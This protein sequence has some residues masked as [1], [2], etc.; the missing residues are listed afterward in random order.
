M[1]CRS[2]GP[3]PA[4]RWRSSENC[5]SPYFP[6]SNYFCMAC[7]NAPR[8]RHDMA[9]GGFE[10]S[11][12]AQRIRIARSNWKACRALRNI[13]LAAISN[14]SPRRAIGISIARRSS[15]ARRCNKACKT[16]LRRAGF[17]GARRP[18]RQRHQMAAPRPESAACGSPRRRAYPPPRSCGRVAEGGGLL[19]RYRVV[20]PY[21]GFESLRLRQFPASSLR[22]QGEVS[23]EAPKEP[24]LPQDISNPSEFARKRFLRMIEYG[25]LPALSPRS[26][27][28]AS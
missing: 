19:N 17:V 6:G 8:P 15:L 5:K 1:L 22:S 24:G 14:S 16:A 13:P 2:C 12:R 26:I 9:P 7:E 10:E 4:V 18:G 27:G 3:P 25:T 23:L 11:D 20:K 28:T 21:R